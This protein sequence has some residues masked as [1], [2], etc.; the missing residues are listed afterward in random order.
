MLRP[1]SHLE[2]FWNI[3]EKSS[4]ITALKPFSCT[5]PYRPLHPCKQLPNT[6]VN[7]CVG[8][9]FEAILKLFLPKLWDQKETH[10]WARN[11]S[12]F[13]RVG[14]HKA[15]FPTRA[16]IFSYL[17][18]LCASVKNSYCDT[19]LDNHDVSGYGLQNYNLSRFVF[20]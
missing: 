15:R 4:E 8:Y 13:S 11:G 6:E 3:L 12:S 2:T 5:V 1:R 19:I 9:N 18:S 14:R 20:L 16:K 7:L 10:C 17:Y